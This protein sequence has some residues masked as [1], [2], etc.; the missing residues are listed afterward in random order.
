MSVDLP[1]GMYQRERSPNQTFDQEEPLYWRLTTESLRSLGH[2]SG[3][4]FRAPNFSVNRGKYSEPNWV[5][6]PS[7][8]DQGIVRLLVKDVPTKEISPPESRYR[9]ACAVVHDPLPENYSHSE[10]RWLKNGRYDKDADIPRTVKK[11]VR[12]QLSQRA[13]VL[14][15]PSA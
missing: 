4:A 11:K 8:T 3:I 13:V 15:K 2:E 5:L 14:K 12:Q 9:Y 7:Y 10:V 6:L 1:D